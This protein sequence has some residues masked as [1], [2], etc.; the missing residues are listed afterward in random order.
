MTGK[1]LLTNASVK[2]RCL[3]TWGKPLRYSWP[4]ITSAVFLKYLCLLIANYH[5]DRSF[6]VQLNGTRYVKLFITMGVPQGS[7][8]GPFLFIIYVKDFFLLFNSTKIKYG[9]IC[10]WNN[11][12][13]VVIQSYLLHQFL[14]RWLEE[15]MLLVWSQSAHRKLISFVHWRFLKWGEG[16][17]HF[18]K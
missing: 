18:S 10:W 14:H 6:I 17:A 8:L 2:L 3:L 1:R 15:N 16:G 7:I 11:Y 9:S 5:T 12:I 4:Y 13:S